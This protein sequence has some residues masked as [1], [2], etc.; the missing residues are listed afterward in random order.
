[1]SKKVI[2]DWNEQQWK[3]IQGRT[4]KLTKAEN[5]SKGDEWKE[6]TPIRGG[7]GGGGEEEVS[8]Y[9]E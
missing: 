4:F 9:N 6:G 2:F 5:S 3:R 7:G 8:S 1:M